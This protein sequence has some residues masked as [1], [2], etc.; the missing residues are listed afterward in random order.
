MDH[1]PMPEKA[2]KKEGEKNPKQVPFLLPVKIQIQQWNGMEGI[3]P[4]DPIIIMQRYVRT[5][6]C[7]FRR[8]SNQVVSGLLRVAA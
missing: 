6:R 7:H 4:N 8:E 1:H 2:E 3:F 5:L